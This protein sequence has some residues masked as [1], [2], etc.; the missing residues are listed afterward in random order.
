MSDKLLNLLAKVQDVNYQYNQ[1]I[2]FCEEPD[3]DY[4]LTYERPF[5][6][7]NYSNNKF[8]LDFVSEHEQEFE[9]LDV[10]TGF[11]VEGPYPLEGLDDVA[12][13]WVSLQVK[14]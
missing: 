3:Y 2:L 6:T 1:Q 5:R 14:E 10:R 12:I 11:R 13:H 8:D 7:D 4:I 9:K